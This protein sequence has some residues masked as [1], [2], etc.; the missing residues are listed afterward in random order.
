MIG[1]LCLYRRETTVM[2]QKSIRVRFTQ[3]FTNHSNVVQRPCTVLLSSLRPRALDGVPNVQ[4]CRRPKF[5]RS[6]GTIRNSGSAQPIERSRF[7]VIFELSGWLQTCTNQ[8]RYPHPREG[9]AMKPT[10]WAQHRKEQERRTIK[11]AAMNYDYEFRKCG[12]KVQPWYALTMISLK[13][14]N[15]EESVGVFAQ[16]DTRN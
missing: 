16:L 4:V 7:S 8:S 11:G 12:S 2:N 10:A 6:I 9:V 15:M 5:S 3:T 14:I 13:V 1:L